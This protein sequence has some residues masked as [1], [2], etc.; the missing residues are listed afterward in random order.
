MFGDRPDMLQR[1]LNAMEREPRP[2]EEEGVDWIAKWFE[3]D[4]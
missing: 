1:F 2:D 4:E 3:P